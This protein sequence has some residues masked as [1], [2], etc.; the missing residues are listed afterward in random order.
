MYFWGILDIQE[1]IERNRLNISL[2]HLAVVANAVK[3]AMSETR[4]HRRK[5][6]RRSAAIDCPRCLAMGA[7]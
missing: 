7:R 3:S 5:N 4:E 2:R 1:K 6:W